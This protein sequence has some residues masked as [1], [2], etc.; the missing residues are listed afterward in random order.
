MQAVGFHGFHACGYVETRLAR[1]AVQNLRLSQ[2]SP[3][4]FKHQE[5]PI[6]P[7][8]TSV[9][10]AQMT[11]IWLV[12]V[13]NQT[14]DRSPVVFRLRQPALYS[15]I[16]EA[17][18]APTSV[19][20]N[21]LPSR[22]RGALIRQRGKDVC[23]L[24]QST[25]RLWSSLP[26]MLIPIALREIICVFAGPVGHCRRFSDRETHQTDDNDAA[27]VVALLLEQKYSHQGRSR[28]CRPPPGI[29]FC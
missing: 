15:K 18:N 27:N 2:G 3:S 7:L 1:L 5:H 10:R 9:R 14:T 11:M 24:S 8:L 26:R 17:W 28:R 21:P 4:F 12:H 6:H 22:C 19:V 23:P 16:R 29:S 13:W 25:C 20:E